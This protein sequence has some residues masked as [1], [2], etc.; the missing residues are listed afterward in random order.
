M[1]NSYK[2]LSPAQVTYRESCKRFRCKNCRKVFKNPNVYQAH[3]N[4]HKIKRANRQYLCRLCQTYHKGLSTFLCH[5]KSHQNSN[6]ETFNFTP[7][8]QMLL[9]DSGQTEVIITTSDGLQIPVTAIHGKGITSVDESIQNHIGEDEVNISRPVSENIIQNL[10]QP[11]ASM[12]QTLSS[13]TLSNLSVSSAMSLMAALCSGTATTLSLAQAN[14]TTTVTNSGCKT[15]SSNDGIQIEIPQQVKA[16]YLN[17]STPSLDDVMKQLHVLSN[18]VDTIIKHLHIPVDDDG[19][20]VPLATSNIEIENHSQQP[21]EIGDEQAED[22]DV[23]VGYPPSYS[24]GQAA[25]EQTQQEYYALSLSQQGHQVLKDDAETGLQTSSTSPDGTKNFLGRNKHSKAVDIWLPSAQQFLGQIPGII[26]Q[27]QESESIQLHAPFVIPLTI[28][29]KV[30]LE[31]RSRGNFAKNL[32]FAICS[33]DERRGK[34][35]SGRVYG[36]ATP[37]SRLDEMKLNAVRDATFKKYPCHPNL[38]DITWKKECVAAID[39]GLRNENRLAKAREQSHSI[40]PP[41]QEDL[42]VQE[43]EQHQRNIAKIDCMEAVHI[44]HENIG[45]DVKANHQ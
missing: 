1:E 5:Q 17:S 38:V 45:S 9:S 15:A 2:T 28:L 19:H 7:Q 31:S 40:F 37:K 27:S 43:P 18:K 8:E 22:Q 41:K 16:I 39:S 34:N 6:H 44:E 36:R 11:M 12:G 26:D 30:F 32:L 35:C 21:K 23:I 10:H 14:L 24:V 33:S 3:L 29:D 42:L 25:K 4:L 20:A 13:D